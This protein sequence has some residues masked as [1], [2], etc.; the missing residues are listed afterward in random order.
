[1]KKGQKTK[2]AYFFSQRTTIENGKSYFAK[3]ERIS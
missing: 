2:R 1:M 3:Q